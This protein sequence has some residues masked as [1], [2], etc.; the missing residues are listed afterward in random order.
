M[1]ITSKCT[2]M[3]NKSLFRTTTVEFLKNKL[4]KERLQNVRF[5]FL[6]LY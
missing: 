6:R 2:G 4:Q 5:D 1:N 3:D